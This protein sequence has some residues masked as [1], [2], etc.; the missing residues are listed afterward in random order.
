MIKYYVDGERVCAKLAREKFKDHYSP[1]NDD[2]VQRMWEE[3]LSNPTV[4]DKMLPASVGL[5]DV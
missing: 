5:E 2:E 1:L 3:C 4:R